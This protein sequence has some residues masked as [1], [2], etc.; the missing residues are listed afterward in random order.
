MTVN[1]EGPGSAT[2]SGTVR[3]ELKVIARACPEV[4]SVALD[5]KDIG[6]L[7]L[8]HG[9]FVASLGEPLAGKLTPVYKND[10]VGG[11]SFK[12][13]AIREKEIAIGLKSIAKAM[14]FGE[15]KL[16]YEI[17]AI[18][19]EEQ[20]YGEDELLW[21]EA[22]L[23]AERQKQE[24]ASQLQAPEDSGIAKGKKLHEEIEAV[25]V[26]ALNLDLSAQQITALLEQ[27]GFLA[28]RSELQSPALDDST[29]F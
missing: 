24:A 4:Y 21:Y 11:G 6:R 25:L 23:S 28:D 10:S 20:D 19:E 13:Q 29:Q 14:N 17:P 1:T 15:A 8:R 2:G 18:K 9:T 3:L 5:G 22:I 27:R 26:E 16:D 7:R 12:T